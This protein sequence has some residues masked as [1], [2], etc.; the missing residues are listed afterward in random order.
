MVAVLIVRRGAIGG[1]ET[2][3][4]FLGR[5]DEAEAG[6]RD[7]AERQSTSF[8]F[9][10]CSDKAYPDFVCLLQDGRMLVVEY[11]NAKNWSNDDSREKRDIAA[12]WE[13]RSNGRCLF[14]MPQ[15]PD[16]EAI[17]RKIAATST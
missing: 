10:T 5:V 14:I 7:I 17:R 6:G 8:W 4:I 11:N 13:K 1:T 9:Q 16:L 2:W 12:V 15:G 3:T